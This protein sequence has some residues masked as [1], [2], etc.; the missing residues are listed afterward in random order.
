MNTAK[1]VPKVTVQILKKTLLVK[2]CVKN[3]YGRG[4]KKL[5]IPTANLPQFNDLLKDN[6]LDTGVYFGWGRVVSPYTNNDKLQEQRGM[7]VPCVANIGK[8]PTFVGQEN[9]I[10]I[11]E[12]HLVDYQCKEDFYNLPLK[13]CLIGYLRNEQKFPSFDAL[14]TQINNDVESSR[15]LDQMSLSSENISQKNAIEGVGD[16]INDWKKYL[17]QGRKI[18]MEY[19]APSAGHKDDLSR[20]QCMVVNHLST[21]IVLRQESDTEE[22]IWAQIPML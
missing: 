17:H 10:N 14:I 16:D 22:I 9:P 7:I 2:G 8:S 12:A 4:S 6:G 20:L 19:L 13:L 18:A 1:A 21:E 3:G 11:I 15:I 5:G